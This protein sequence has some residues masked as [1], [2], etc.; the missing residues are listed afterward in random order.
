MKKRFLAASLATMMVLSLAACGGGER[1]PIPRQLLQPQ[2]HR[3]IPKRRTK[4]RT[5]RHRLKLQAGRL[6]RIIREPWWYIRPM[7]QIL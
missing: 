4:Q 6:L 2:R 1:R 5:L 3:L 7:T